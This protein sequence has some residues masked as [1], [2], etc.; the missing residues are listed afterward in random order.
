MRF[1]FLNNNEISCQFCGYTPPQH[2]QPRSGTWFCPKCGK[3]VSIS[4]PVILPRQSHSKKLPRRQKTR[5]QI[6]NQI[7]SNITKTSTPDLGLKEQ[8]LKPVVEPIIPKKR[9]K[10]RIFSKGAEE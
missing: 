3:R 7:Y 10:I 8:Y 4:Q 2:E 6:S 5:D 9:N 1:Q